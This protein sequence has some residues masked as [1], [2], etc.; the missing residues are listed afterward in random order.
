MDTATCIAGAVLDP[1]DISVEVLSIGAVEAK[2]HGAREGRCAAAAIRAHP[3][4]ARA[5]PLYR[6]A[7][8]KGNPDRVMGAD[9]SLTLLPLLAQQRRMQ[10]TFADVA[11][12]GFSD[13]PTV[14]VVIGHSIRNAHAT[15]G[16]TLCPLSGLWETAVLV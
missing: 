9:S 10:L 5:I 14:W 13:Q 12:S 15:C 7:S 1:H 3:T 6:R 2:P 4:A 8:S 11:Q 16:G